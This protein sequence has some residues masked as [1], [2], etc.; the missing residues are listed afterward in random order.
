MRSSDRTAVRPDHPVDDLGFFLQDPSPQAAQRFTS[1]LVELQ[2]RMWTLR[3]PELVD[4]QDEGIACRNLG[5]VLE[6]FCGHPP[7]ADK[8]PAEVDAAQ[9]RETRALL[10]DL[11][12]LSRR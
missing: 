1:F 10:Q 2:N 8:L 9:F 6:L 4:E 11:C 3:A 12:S 5:G 7:W